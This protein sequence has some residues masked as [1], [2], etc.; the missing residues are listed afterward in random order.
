KR[1]VFLEIWRV[2]NDNGR[3][4]VSDIIS[5]F[6]PNDEIKTNKQLWGECLA[7]ALTENQFLSYLE[8]TGFYG[9]EILSKSHWKT[10]EKIN[11]YSVTLRAFKYDKSSSCVFKGHKAVYNGPYKVI[12]D[13]EGHV[14]QRN[15]EVE[16]CTD[17]VNKLSHPPYQNCFT[18]IEPAGDLSEA[19]CSPGDTESCC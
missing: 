7:G 4:V 6:E 16:V 3:I 5:D 14:F 12:I 1:K 13:D 8:Q 11:F 10:I 19:C 9:I 2:L 17:T 15:Q 18:I